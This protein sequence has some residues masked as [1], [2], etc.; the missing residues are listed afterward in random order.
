[1]GNRY[2]APP[3]KS[4]I[5]SNTKTINS[6][7]KRWRPG[8]CDWLHPTFKSLNGSRTKNI[9]NSPIQGGLQFLYQFQKTGFISSIELFVLFVNSK[10]ISWRPILQCHKLTDPISI[11]W[12][13]CFVFVAKRSLTDKCSYFEFPTDKWKVLDCAKKNLS[14]KSLLVSTLP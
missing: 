2:W 7:M 5:S 14:V 1:M 11:L 4:S 12:L 6:S 13:D 10:M 3:A 9:L 8:I